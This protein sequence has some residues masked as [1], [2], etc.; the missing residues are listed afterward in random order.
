[1]DEAT[2]GIIIAL[3]VPFLGTAIGSSFAF[4]LKHTMGEIPQKVLLGFAAGV[5]MAAS[6]WSLL[7]PAIESA[8]DQGSIGW[9][10][11][12][13]GFL[14]GIGLLLLFDH[15]LPHQHLD[16]PGPEGIKSRMKRPTMLIFAVALHNLPEGMAVGVVLA[17]FL[18]G[19]ASITL[20]GLISLTIGIAIQNIPEGAII[21]TPLVSSGLSRKKAFAYGI[22]SGAIEPLGA[23]LMIAFVGIMTPA[24]PYILSFAAGAMVY[25]VVEELIPET[26]A[27]RHTNVGV[28]AFALGFMLMMIL[29]V[30]LG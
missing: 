4:I 22:M 30:A 19:Q 28:I 23:L 14:L 11:A 2:L 12:S 16:Q 26:Q 29:D 13:V 10:P 9:L 18:T 20:A 24:L 17:G 15:L 27:G 25:V 5:M 6:I 3:T 7:I 1:M 21:S 8:E